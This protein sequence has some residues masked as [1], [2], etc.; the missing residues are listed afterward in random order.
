MIRT[1]IPPVSWL[2]LN[3]DV[4]EGPPLPDNIMHRSPQPTI[5]LIR[6]T[7]LATLK[8]RDVSRVK[9][10]NAQRMMQLGSALK[11]SRLDNARDTIVHEV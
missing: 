2:V 9:R 6:N 3:G 1:I 4:D 7:D 11:G 8:A 10:M 5:H